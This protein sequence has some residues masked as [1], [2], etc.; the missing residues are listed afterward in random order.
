MAVRQF[1]VR[2]EKTGAVVVVLYAFTV[3]GSQKMP[4]VESKK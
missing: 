4:V 2:G 3:E 1:A